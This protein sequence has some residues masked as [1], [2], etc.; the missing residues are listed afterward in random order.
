MEYIKLAG[1]LLVLLGSIVL[2]ISSIGLIRM[3]DVYN[4]VQTSTKSSTLGAILSMIGIGVITPDWLGKVFILVVFIMITNPVSS[5][6]IMRAAHYSKIPLTKRT[7]VDY[8]EKDKIELK[9]KETEE[10]E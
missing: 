1:A 8:L 9:E 6:A 2:L 7:V 4:R 5:H 10:K 3:P